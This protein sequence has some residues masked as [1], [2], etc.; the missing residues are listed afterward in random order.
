MVSIFKT[1]L[2]T[3][4]SKDLV[5]T[6][7]KTYVSTH[8]AELKR[9]SELYWARN[10]CRAA[11]KGKEDDANVYRA[12]WSAEYWAR[13]A[14]E[15]L[16][17][18][19]TTTVKEAEKICTP[20]LVVE[21]KVEEET[22]EEEKAE[23]KKVVEEVEKEQKE[24][25]IV[26]LA[27]ADD[28]EADELSMMSW[29]PEEQEETTMEQ[30]IS[31]PVAAQSPT[32]STGTYL[33][34]H[35]Q[36]LAALSDKYFAEQAELGLPF[37]MGHVE[38]T[39]YMVDEGKV[40]H[41][42][43]W[44]AT[45]HSAFRVE[46]ARRG[47][48]MSEARLAARGPAVF[49]VWEDD[50]DEEE[51]QQQQQSRGPV[52]YKVWEDDEE[53][54]EEKEEQQQQQYEDASDVECFV[55]S[56]EKDVDA[57]DVDEPMLEEQVEVSLSDHEKDVFVEAVE[58]LVESE[59]QE[60]EVQQPEVAIEQLTVGF[61]VEQMAVDMV[62]E[63]A[64]DK[65]EKREE[66]AGELVVVSWPVVEVQMLVVEE[67]EPVPV[68]WPPEE[69]QVQE[70]LQAQE[71]RPEVTVEDARVETQQED[72]EGKMEEETEKVEEQVKEDMKEEEQQQ[73]QELQEQEQEL[74]EQEEKQEENQ[75]QRQE[76]EHEQEQEQERQKT[77]STLRR[78]GRQ[79]KQAKPRAAPYQSLRTLG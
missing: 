73:E 7:Q 25:R 62:T 30:S 46:A 23:E 69:V 13:A 70:V 1:A 29:A 21:E 26:C 50:E 72:A 38:L 11:A 18:R 22:V 52:A 53:E 42:I 55:E 20:E 66:E 2:A 47:R 48:I 37:E 75:E 44:L 17:L 71:V 39:D 54:E 76:Q 15:E 43:V 14:E 4:S 57:M 10:G 63:L 6:V 5:S 24:E 61:H 16:P 41:D 59:K 19:R 49:K 12:R 32:G 78:S 8:S 77:I 60:G 31:A 9:L 27:V 68:P 36:E 34:R 28:S 33:S 3:S 51:Q 45:S 58:E 40:E 65:Q 56:T 74:Q 35:A 79:R 64:Q 67:E